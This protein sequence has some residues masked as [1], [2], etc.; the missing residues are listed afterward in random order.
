M[1]VRPGNTRP[2]RPPRRRRLSLDAPGAQVEITERD[3]GVL[4]LRPCV[5]VPLDQAWFWTPQWQQREREAD[6]DVTAGR[7]TT[8]D[9]ADAFVAHLDELDASE[10]SQQ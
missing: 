1:R 7:V 6:D 2:G 8:F 3:D 9:D 4:E 5:P 10:R